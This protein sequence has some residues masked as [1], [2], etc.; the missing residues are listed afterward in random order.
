MCQL[1]PLM[2]DFFWQIF[3]FTVFTLFF[4]GRVNVFFVVFE[5]FG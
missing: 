5:I 3:Q 1:L 4:Q 2:V